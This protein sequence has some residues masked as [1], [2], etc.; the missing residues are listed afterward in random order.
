[1]ELSLSDGMEKSQSDVGSCP[2]RT[3]V[4]RTAALQEAWPAARL[5]NPRSCSTE[6]L[7]CIRRLADLHSPPV[8]S[9]VCHFLHIARVKVLLQRCSGGC[10]ECRDAVVGRS[11]AAACRCA[12]TIACSAGGLLCG[13]RQTS[14]PVE[15]VRGWE[16][17]TV[18]S[19]THGDGG[20]GHHGLRTLQM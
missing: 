16:P 3:L 20:R 1:M 13:L 14:S 15:G 7:S 18:S 5:L 17:T 9:P 2:S 10:L 19:T 12:A 4:E 8:A 6:S 11:A